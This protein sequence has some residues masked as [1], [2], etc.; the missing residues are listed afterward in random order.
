MRR[1]LAHL[2]DVRVGQRVA[3]ADVFEV[4]KQGRPVI[5]DMASLLD[6]QRCHNSGAGAFPRPNRLVAPRICG[7]DQITF[8]YRIAGHQMTRYADITNDGP[9]VI[10]SIFNPKQLLS[11]P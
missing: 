9:F 8:D 4:G 2:N 7:S 10:G 5:A 1:R 3:R 6:G 11:R